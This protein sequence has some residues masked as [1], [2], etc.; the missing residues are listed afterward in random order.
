MKRHS[1]TSSFYYRPVV[2]QPYNIHQWVALVA[3]FLRPMVFKCCLK[4]CGLHLEV[5]QPTF[6][7]SFNL[8]CK[9]DD[10]PTTWGWNDRMPDWMLRLRLYKVVMNKEV[11]SRGKG[12]ACA[13]LSR[14]GLG[15][16]ALV[17]VHCARAIRLR[18]LLTSKCIP[19]P[20][21]FLIL[22]YWDYCRHTEIRERKI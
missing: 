19:F 6:S 16:R 17:V 20:F 18:V 10:W 3:R 9:N 4:Y 14:V 21:F 8:V 15:A 12:M 7:I 11:S 5:R 22:R 1:P 13:W 2:I